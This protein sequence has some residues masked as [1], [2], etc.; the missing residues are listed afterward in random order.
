MRI[1]RIIATEVIVPAKPGSINSPSL[2]RP[3]H[4]LESVGQKA[5]TKQ[6]DEFPKLI[7]QLELDNGVV[8]LGECYRDHDWRIIESIT[9]TLLGQTISSLK[10]QE[11]PIAFCR[12]YDGFECA[13]WD[14]FARSHQMPLVDL[15]GGALRREI[16]VSAWTGHRTLDEMGDIARRFAADGYTCWKLKCDLEDDVV[17]WSMEIAR[18]APSLKVILDPNERWAQPDEAKKRLRELDRIG[19]VL[20]VED[21]IPHWMVDE[22]ADLRRFSAIPIVR[23]VSLPYIA[24]GQRVHDAIVSVQ[25][26]AV[27]GFNFNGGLAKFQQLAHIASAAELPCWHG[28]ELDLGIL[29]AM[30]VHQCAAAQSC[31]LP[32]DIFGQLVRSHD[33]LAV[34]LSFHPPYVS[35]PDGI[36]LGVEPDMAAIAAYQTQKREFTYEPV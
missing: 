10:R 22:Y 30:Y 20:C 8:G 25:K 12:E 21:P 26:R 33:L 35:L 4:K 1:V 23:H 27:D 11:L 14:A 5:W 19:N 13:I 2:D 18:T 7:L 9:Q 32:S 6:F 15:L 34:P 36:G 17:G 28:S 29:E 3:L 31:T 16:L 24:H